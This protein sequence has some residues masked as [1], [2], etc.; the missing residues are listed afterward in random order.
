MINNALNQ[1]TLQLYKQQY[2]FSV[3][4]V[5]NDTCIP[6]YVRWATGYFDNPY[7]DS[8]HTS[9]NINLPICMACCHI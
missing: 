6:P 2:Y 5:L 4:L 1:A 9:A 8:L 3:Q 7:Q